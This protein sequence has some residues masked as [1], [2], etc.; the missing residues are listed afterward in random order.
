MVTKTTMHIN[1]QEYCMCICWF[2][3]IPN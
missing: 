1:V 3:T 2:V